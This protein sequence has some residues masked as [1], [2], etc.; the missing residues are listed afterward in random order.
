MSTRAP[1][2]QGRRLVAPGWC[3]VASTPGGHGNLAAPCRRNHEGTSPMTILDR[4]L[5][6]A[7]LAALLS[8][9]AGAQAPATTPVIPQV[10]T[11]CHQARPDALQGIYENVAFKSQ[12]LQLKID[13]HTEVVRFDPKTL[14]VVD[15]GVAKPAEALRDLP[16]NKEARIDYVVQDGARVARQITFK[17]PIKIARDKVV[18]YEEV[19]RLV[20]LGPDKGNFT[21]IDSR[22]LPRVQEGTIPGAINLP[23]PAFD[24]FVDRLPKD[25]GRLTVFFC[26]GVTCVMSP[27]SLRKAEAL[28]Y[29]NVKVYPEGYPEWSERNVGVLAAPHLKEAWLDKGIPHVLVDARPAALAREGTIPGAVSIPPSQVVAAL[30]RFPD[31]RLKA[32]IIVYDFDGGTSALQVARVIKA[33]GQPNVTVLTGGYDAWQGAKL[34]VAK[35][36]L[37]TTVAYVP[38]PRP[39][40]IPNEEFL[41]IVKEAPADVIVLDVRNSDEANAGMIKGARLIPDEDLLARI[42]ELPKDKRI[43][44]HCSTG[45][46]AEMAYHKL[47]AAGYQAGFVYADLDINRKGEVKL[48]PKL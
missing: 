15:A 2:P 45:V 19:L 34:P 1:A 6:A 37:V 29:T 7:V 14:K 12:S 28:G 43:V 11:N 48:T 21:L 35:A 24:K 25:K 46:R 47:K 18:G 42:A 26:Q 16:K 32:P 33:S 44:A 38:K 27:N 13:A 30:P 22:P 20:T 8:A 5:L 4:G 36:P 3:P 10:C 17:G 23:Y 41:R 9:P 31:A 40:S 39:G